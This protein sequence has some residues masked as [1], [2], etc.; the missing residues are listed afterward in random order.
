MDP[1]ELAGHVKVAIEGNQ[2]HEVPYPEAALRGWAA[3]RVELVSRR[4]AS[5]PV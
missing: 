3:E 4:S 1:V 2:L 5:A